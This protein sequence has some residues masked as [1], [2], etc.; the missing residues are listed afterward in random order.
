MY[1]NDGMCGRVKVADVAG[2]VQEE[3][4]RWF[5]HVMKRH[6]ELNRQESSD[7]LCD[8]SIKRGR[9]ENKWR[10]NIKERQKTSGVNLAKSP[11]SC[12]C[13]SKYLRF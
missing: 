9:P 4:F 10:D 3:M 6:E 2:N 13:H 1:W 7:F 11:S 8:G 12:L 5:G